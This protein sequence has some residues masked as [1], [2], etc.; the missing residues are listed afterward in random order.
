MTAATTCRTCGNQLRE[1]ARFCDGCGA[2]ISKK[3]TH[4]EYKQVTVLFAD[5]VHSMD[6]AA[7][8]GPERLREIMADVAD[9]SAAVV[10]RYG[11]TVD[12]FT[13]DG[14]MAL[15]GAP[16]ALE[17]HAL[18]A[19]LA[20]LDVQE[21]AKRLAVVVLE[22]DGVYLQLR[23]GLNSGE[24]IAGE[25]G[26]GPFGYT[27]VGEQVGMAQRMESAASPGGVMLS[28][29]T[30][31]LVEHTAVLGERELVHIKGAEAAVPARHLLE[32]RSERARPSAREPTLVGRLQE[33][34]TV[35]GMLD[36][37]VNGDGCVAGIAGPPGIGKSRMVDE[38]VKLAADRGFEVYSTFCESHARG[39][40]FRVGARLLRKVFGVSD[41]APAAAWAQIQTRCP[42]ADYEDLLLL[43]DLLGV[44]DPGVALPAIPPDARR[45]RLAIQ[46]KVVAQ[47]I[48]TPAMYVIEDAH[49]IDEASETMLAEF[50]SSIAEL[51]LLVL[52]S[53]RPEYRGTLSQISGGKTIALA[54]LSSAQTRELISELLG[55]HPSVT[56][57]AAQVADRAAG[58][59][60][61]ASEMVRDLAERGV[62]RGDRGTYICR[63]GY[64][65]IS[66]PP[67]LQA[68][69]AA[70]VDRLSDPAKRVLYA[71]AVIGARFR[72]DL[73]DI[74]L[75]ENGRFETVLNE[76]L[77]AEIIDQV[78]SAPSVEF[79]FRH[80]LIRTV[81]YE[82]QLRV[83]R[84]DLHRRVANA[85]TESEPALADQ[86]AALIA[87]HLESAGDLRAAFD[88]HTRAGS[89][90]IDRDRA[91]ARSRWQ[92][93]RLLADKMP[94]DDAD[95]IALQIASRTLLCSTVWLT[96]G[97]AD[98]VG[99]EELRELCAVRGDDVSL[100]IGMAGVVMALAG[101]NRLREASQLASDL[102]ELTEAI[103]N[104]RLTA[105]LLSSAIYAK[106]EV[107]EMTEALRLAQLVIDLADGDA[108]T[109]R[110]QLPGSPLTMATQMRGLVRLCLGINGWRSDADA[111]I[112]MAAS[113]GP[114]EYVAAIFY[115]YI[116][117]IPIGARSVTPTALRETRDA[118]R[119][120]ERT[121]D[122][123]TLCLAQLTRGLAL[124]HHVGRHREEGF[125]LLK[126]AREAA[127]KE[128]FTMNALAVVD[129]EIAREK[130]RNGDIDGAI[131]LSRAAI[132]DMF[133]NGA[134]FL[135]GAATTVLVESL[136]ARESGSDLQ[137][138]EAAIE[139]LAT[140]PT[141]AGLVL[142]QL[143]L[144]RLRALLARTLSDEA[145]Y[146]N[147][148]DRY[149]DMATA[150]E[151][152]GH[153]ARAKAMP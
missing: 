137:E 131:Q 24:V 76:L 36:R 79:A 31:R 90:S 129:P 153:I 9:R 142:Y 138:A 118:L 73:L 57:L 130:A 4:A 112:T 39:I 29:S 70:R 54:P 141:D 128:G 7:S 107:G 78:E 69:I 82:S 134:L 48:A 127:A 8:V 66:V 91:T 103:G 68:T 46:L 55:D 51:R 106:T 105:G 114:R 64:G 15:F 34:G 95:R 67:T 42:D 33:T 61:F 19:C 16:V 89:W 18:R 43:A 41:T 1:G 92:R 147:Y 109:K 56:A 28:E 108:P 85:I 98:D 75:H 35:G 21:E 150:L 115:K 143:P 38:A 72:P 86:N 101:Q 58:N 11:G 102:T 20:A 49:W 14:I 126:Q 125:H 132:D 121:S 123:Y 96:G 94:A 65:A 111:A 74:I 100:A 53:Y 133:A 60:F 145:A 62:L 104:S 99:F 44:G 63:E 116:V 23:V 113:L 27:A 152:E 146:R 148:R 120:A 50:I 122:D 12:K 139:R 77:E 37:A 30:A 25:I 124:V 151:F 17:D 3:D 2:P 32:A 5:V 6:I 135:R 45:R 87:D 10:Q 88:W 71:G 59:P 140:I 144:L 110:A 97:S 22:R 117:A 119:T 40:P 93:A 52:V 47:Q 149:L 81:A 136:L 84:A 13:G 26:S 80:P 83:E